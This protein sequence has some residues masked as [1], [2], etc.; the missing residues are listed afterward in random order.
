MSSARAWAA[1]AA[2]AWAESRARREGV[3]TRT[4]RGAPDLQRSRPEDARALVLGHVRRRDA[5]LDADGPLRDA[6]LAWPVNLH[7]VVTADAVHL[8]A[9]LALLALLALAVSHQVLLQL[10]IVE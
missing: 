5:I 4:E 3:R 8:G 1:A 2:A 7:D 9:L 10:V 6:V